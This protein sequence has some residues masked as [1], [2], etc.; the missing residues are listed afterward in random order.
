[1]S[2]MPAH[3]RR[4]LTPAT[5]G[6]SSST[7]AA[8][9]LQERQRRALAVRRVRIDLRADDELAAVGLVDVDVER[10]RHEHRVE[11]R[12]ERLGHERLERVG[13]DRDPHA[14]HRRDR[15]RPAGRR[16]DDDPGPDRAARWSGRRSTRPSATSIPVTSVY[17]WI[18]TPF[19]SARRA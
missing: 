16:V 12:L 18:S 7:C 19:S 8:D 1:M 13:D 5:D 3:W 9:D 17:W 6:S 15:R 2:Q 10:R 11:E 4:T 14:D